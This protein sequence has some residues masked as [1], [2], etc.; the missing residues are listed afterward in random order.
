MSQAERFQALHEGRQA[1]AKGHP[2][3]ACPHSHGD[4][5]RTAWVQG[6]AA[7]P[8]SLTKVDYSS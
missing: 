6:F 4:P 1:A 7:H 5:L 3:T 2:V 8:G